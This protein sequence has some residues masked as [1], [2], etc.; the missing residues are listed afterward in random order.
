[1]ALAA[2]LRHRL[3]ERDVEPHR[4]D[5]GAR[6]HHVVGRRAAQAQ[7]VGDQ[8]PFLPVE[9]R[10][11]A[12]HRA[13]PPPPPAPVRRST[14]ARSCSFGRPPACRPTQPVRSRLG[15]RERAH[16]RRHGFGQAE[17]V[18]DARLRHLHAPRVARMM[19]VVPL[20]MQRAV[21][22]EMREMVRRPRPGLGRLAPH[23]AEREHDLPARVIGGLEG[24][25][26]G[27]LV[28]AAMPR[29]QPFH[30]DVGGQHDAAPPRRPRARRG[31]RKRLGPPHE[32]AP[33]RIVDQHAG[34]P[35]CRRTRH[36]F[37]ERRAISDF[38]APRLRG[39]PTV[40]RRH[41]YLPEPSAPTAPATPF[42]RLRRALVSFSAAARCS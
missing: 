2:D 4:D 38:A 39:E 7:H 11:L 27:R 6:D 37:D 18:Q 17:P 23:R 3:V 25:H 34:R 36:R 8:R 22:D 13:A 10:R 5:V 35:R 9:F 41:T 15:T 20:Q 40:V 24:Q 14:R 32:P 19:V 26:V 1:M 42:A 29:V 16:A 28:A 33:R 30:V 12:G 31:A 21:H